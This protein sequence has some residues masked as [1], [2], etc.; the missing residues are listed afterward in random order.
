MCFYFCLYF[1]CFYEYIHRVCVYK[2]AYCWGKKLPTY[3]PYF[4]VARYFLALLSDYNYAWI[5][6]SCVPS[7]LNEAWG[8]FSKPTSCHHWVELFI[9]EPCQTECSCNVIC[10]GM[11]NHAVRICI[12]SRR[13]NSMF[14][15]KNLNILTFTHFWYNNFEGQRTNMISLSGTILRQ[16]I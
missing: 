6:P 8:I 13:L 16:Y 1:L 5:L 14:K 2:W 4:S 11:C 10:Q 9:H 7:L 12:L 3:L 15:K